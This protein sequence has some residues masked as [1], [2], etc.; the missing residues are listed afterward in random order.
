[1]NLFLNNIGKWL[2]NKKTFL[3][4]RTS[5]AGRITPRTQHGRS[6]QGNGLSIFSLNSFLNF[7]SF[8]EMTASQ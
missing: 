7:S 4:G 8:G 5:G 3:A 1:M 2:N 6:Y